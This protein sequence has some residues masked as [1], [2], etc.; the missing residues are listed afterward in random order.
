MIVQNGVSLYEVAEI[1]G[2]SSLSTTRRHANIVPDALRGTAERLDGALSG[3][4]QSAWGGQT[5]L[6]ELRLVTL[7]ELEGVQE[8]LQDCIAVFQA[9]VDDCF[10]I[11]E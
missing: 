8:P 2:H 6:L 5:L 11:A 7:L 9:S 4:A 3:A 10:E 1:L